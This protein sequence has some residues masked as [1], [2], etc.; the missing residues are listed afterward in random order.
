M[1][2]IL[3]SRMDLN[4]Y[5]TPNSGNK[6]EINNFRDLNY[7][8]KIYDKQNDEFKGVYVCN[9]ME[10]IIVSNTIKVIKYRFDNEHVNKFFNDL[11]NKKINYITDNSPY[12]T[13][14]YIILVDKVRKIIL[15][16]PHIDELTKVFINEGYEDFNKIT[17]E[18]K[19]HQYE[20]L[21][22]N[23]NYVVN[24]SIEFFK[25][26]TSDATMNVQHEYRIGNSTTDPKIQSLKRDNEI[27]HKRVNNNIV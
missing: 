10:D 23:Y 7:G 11:N 12:G 3:I 14:G 8:D 25:L 20:I 19:S 17:D 13:K 9:K 22:D 26:A 1:T 27:A 16:E 21:D 24:G 5:S 4:K 15:Y 2:R 6:K 18:L